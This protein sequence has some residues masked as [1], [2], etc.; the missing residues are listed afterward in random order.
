MAIGSL[1]AIIAV[2]KYLADGGARSVTVKIG[3]P[4]EMADH[5]DYY[6]PFEIDGIGRG[7]IDHACGVDAIQ[8]LDLAMKKIGV[9]LNFS[10][11]AQA[12]RLSWDGGGDHFGLPLPDSC[13]DAE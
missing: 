12:A 13:T 6:C 11:E 8:A 2:R 3:K 10:P 7:G 5:S 9:I 1:G 4:E